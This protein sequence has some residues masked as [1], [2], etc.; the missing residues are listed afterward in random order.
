MIFLQISRFYLRWTKI[1][2]TLFIC[3]T[4]TKIR[5][6]YDILI[7]IYLIVNRKKNTTLIVFAMDAPFSRYPNMSLPAR[8]HDSV[9]LYVLQNFVFRKYNRFAAN[10]KKFAI[11]SDFYLVYSIHILTSCKILTSMYTC[12]LSKFYVNIFFLYV[13]I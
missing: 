9:E 12:A 10:W 7:N 5:M 6:T 8:I 11:S 2:H 3:K 13:T 1:T 4:L